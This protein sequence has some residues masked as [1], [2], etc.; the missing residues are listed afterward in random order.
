MAK[1]A[2]DS[3]YTKGGSWYGVRAQVKH[4]IDGFNTVVVYNAMA[5]LDHL[6]QRLASEAVREVH[7]TVEAIKVW[8][9]VDLF[10]D[11]R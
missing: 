2:R 7:Q 10:E 6:D 4:R 1:G 11:Y 3:G 9:K 5:Q 8:P